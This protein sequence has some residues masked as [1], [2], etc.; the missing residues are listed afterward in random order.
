MATVT[1]YNLL[2]PCNW[3]F[4]IK[5]FTPL[6]TIQHHVLYKQSTELYTVFAID[7]CF[8]AMSSR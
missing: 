3:I 8:V 5:L 1:C 2:V 7:T 4:I 6:R